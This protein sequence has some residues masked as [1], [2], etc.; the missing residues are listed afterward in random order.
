MTQPNCP[1]CPFNRKDKR[2]LHISAPVDE[3]VALFVTE[4]PTNEDEQMGRLLSG[5]V[6]QELDTS[7]CKAGLNRRQLV[8]AAPI[9]CRPTTFNPKDM[10]AARKCCAPAFRDVTAPYNHL[11]KFLAGKQSAVSYMKLP[12][13]GVD[14]ARGFIREE[15]KAIVSWEPKFA[16]FIAPKHWAAFDVDLQRFG[17]LVRGHLGAAAKIRTGVSAD[18]IKAFGAA[19]HVLAFDIETAPADP[20]RPWTGKSP[21]E[22]RLKSIGFGTETEGIA[23]MWEAVGQDVEVAIRDVLANPAVLKVG[24]NSTFFDIPVLQRYGLEVVNHVDARDLRRALSATSRLSLRYAA[25]LYV[26]GPPW[27]E[28][29]VAEDDEVK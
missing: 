5:S 1:A 28:D 13:G 4:S 25:S 29:E 2:P 16:Y 18:C 21:V 3:P 6:G 19:N 17:R 15:I 27:K 8:V 10:D 12:K 24:W 26:D 9:A 7:L 20:A 23:V 14:N 11:P 22:A